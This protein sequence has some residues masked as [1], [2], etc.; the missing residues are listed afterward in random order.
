MLGAPNSPARQAG[1]PLSFLTFSQIWNRLLDQSPRR[2]G[3]PALR[4][5]QRNPRQTDKLQI[6]SWNPGPARGSDPSLLASHLNG[7]WHVICVQEG[8]GSVTDSSL[9]EN[10]HAITHDHCAVLLNNDT[11]ARDF[12]CAPIQVPCSLRYSSGAV[13]GMVVTG[14]FRRAPDPSCAYFKSARA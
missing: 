14:K 13:E 7:P 9:A 4:S 10:F 8:S 1:T 12:S 11:F 5:D 2:S 6:L 3:G